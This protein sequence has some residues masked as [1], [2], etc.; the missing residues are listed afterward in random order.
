MR[1]RCMQR[2]YWLLIWQAVWHARWLYGAEVEAVY[3]LEGMGLV[4]A[5]LVGVVALRGTRLE[6]PMQAR[7]VRRDGQCAMRNA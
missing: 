4:L 7:D 6:E 3:Y 1:R 2:L 5:G